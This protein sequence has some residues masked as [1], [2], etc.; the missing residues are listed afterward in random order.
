MI[1]R[2]LEAQLAVSG[3]DTPVVRTEQLRCEDDTFLSLEAYGVRLGI[4]SNDVDAI[5]QIQSRLPPGWQICPASKVTHWF[6]L[7][8]QHSCATS[9]LAR[10]DAQQQYVLFVGQDQELTSPRLEPVI[11]ELDWQL[12]LAIAMNVRDRLFVHAG[13][14]GW[15]G[16][17][18]V[19]PGRSFSGKSSLV[20]ALIEAGATYYSDEYAVFDSQGQVYPYLRPLS[21]RKGIGKRPGFYSAQQLGAVSGHNPLPVGLIL[22]TNYRAGTTW[23]PSTLS[24]GEA[25]LALFENTIAARANP[26]YALRTLGT[27]V[28]GSSALAG[29][30]GEAHE[31][32]EEI[33]K[34]F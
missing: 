12:R 5:K 24:P 30:R 22:V 26:K 4:R 31:I 15:Q 17:A 1:V 28:S 25:M 3:E 14:V 29:P 2:P 8:K 10:M 7:I 21:L 9:R 13:V 6:S 18:I 20:T 23:Q 16:S 19:I 11:H 33:R 27:V 34:S 32:A